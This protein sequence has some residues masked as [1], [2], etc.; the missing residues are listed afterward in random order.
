MDAVTIE[1]SPPGE[2]EPDTLA[3]S[4]STD[5]SDAPSNGAT[6]LDDRVVARLRHLAARSELKGELGKTVVLHGDEGSTIRRVVVAGVGKRAEVDA[7]AMRTA[8]SAVV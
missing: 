1:V 7:D 6:Q 2:T 8:A 4:Y 3:D 5:D